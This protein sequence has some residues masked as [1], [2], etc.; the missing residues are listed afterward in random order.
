M[1]VVAVAVLGVCAVL[2]ICAGVARATTGGGGT[3]ATAPV[4]TPGVQE[5]G[6]T[7]SFPD[8]CG[9]QYEYWVL[10]LEKGDLVKITWGSPA[11]V[12]MLALWPQGTNDESNNG[13]LYDSGFSHWNATPV[14]TDRNDTPATNH[15][16]QK[17]APQDGNYPLLFLDTTGAVNAGAYSFT[18]VVQHAAA[19]SFSHQSAIPGAGTFTALVRAPD[20]EPISDS[21]LKLTLTGYWSNRA[22]KLGTATP[23]AGRV[24]FTYSLPASLWGKKIRLD[25]SGGGSGSDYQAVTSQKESVKVLI[26]TDTPVL[27]SASEI[28]AASKL[29]RQPI[30]WDGPRKGFHYEFTRTTTG[31]SYVRYLPRGVH[32][33]DPRAKFLIVATYPYRGAYAALKKYAHGKFGSGADGSIYFVHPGYPKSVYIAWPK[34][35]FEIEVYDPKPAVAKSIAASG[36]VVAIG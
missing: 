28:K 1:K 12:D 29:L 17:V 3:I 8:N 35:N 2:A 31:Y 9:N 11:A 5:D 25:I 14:L 32:A 23:V 27:I 16:A 33:G 22:H 26:P 13:C 21:G 34:V 7:A 6:D 18:A 15:L 20:T 19:I 24:T 30:Y 10:Q 4:V 36:S